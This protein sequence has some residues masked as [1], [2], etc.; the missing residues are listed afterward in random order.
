MAE[1]GVACT[2]LTAELIELERLPIS[3]LMKAC[4]ESANAAREE[5]SRAE[6][7]VIRLDGWLV[8]AKAELRQLAEGA[9]PLVERLHQVTV[10]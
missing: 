9:A 1:Q 8:E 7:L 2:L 6:G 5:Q 10:M 4:E 3:A